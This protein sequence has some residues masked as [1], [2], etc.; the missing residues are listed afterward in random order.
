[1]EKFLIKKAIEKLQETTEGKDLKV[2]K[3]YIE[4][5]VITLETKDKKYYVDILLSNIYK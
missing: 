2:L 1:M 5:D 3:S 4:D